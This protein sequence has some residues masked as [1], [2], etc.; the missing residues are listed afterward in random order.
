MPRRLRFSPPGYWLHLT[1]RGNNKQ[2]VFTADENRHHFLTLVGTLSEERQVRVA[3]YTLMAN[4]FHLFAV[5]DRA[6]ANTPPT[7]MPRN[8]PP[9]AQLTTFGTTVST[10]AS[11]KCPLANRSPLR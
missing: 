1:Q 3:A 11:R 8:A 5:D 10:L 9:V 2:P 6:E 7:A 4:H